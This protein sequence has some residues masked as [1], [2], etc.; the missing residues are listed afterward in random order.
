[1]DQKLAVG[2]ICFMLLVL[3]FMNVASSLHVFSERMV[4]IIFLIQILGLH[5]ESCSKALRFIFT[6]GFV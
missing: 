6:L 2:L 4:S 1:M 5:Y 3:R